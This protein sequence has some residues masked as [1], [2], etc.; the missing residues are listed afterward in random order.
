[1][2][3]DLKV[4]VRVYLPMYTE[5][6]LFCSCK[7]TE[8]ES[9]TLVCPVCMGA[10][11]AYPSLNR[12]AVIIGTLAAMLLDCTINT[13]VSFER[14]LCD[15]VLSPKGY[16]ITQLSNPLGVSGSFFYGKNDSKKS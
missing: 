9:D 13:T 3:E 7:S 1:M 16:K 8:G 14:K 2:N 6:K 11:G 4:G 15:P 12:S 10:P 5:T